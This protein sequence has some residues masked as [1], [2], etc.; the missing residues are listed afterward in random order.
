MRPVLLRPPLPRTPS[1]KD[2]TGF[3]FHS[4]RRSTIT[5]CRREG[6]VGL[7]VFSAIASD[8]RRYVDPLT[9]TKG[10]DG[11]LI[12]RAPAWAPTHTL[13]LAHDAD[14]VHGGNIDAKQALDC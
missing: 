4:S 12:I 3:P 14:R 11:F 5:S 6:V 2:L 8:S 9:L 13:Q 10:H 7:N 1:V